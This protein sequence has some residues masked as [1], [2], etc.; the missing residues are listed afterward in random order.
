[1]LRKGEYRIRAQRFLTGEFHVDDLNRLLLYLRENSFGNQ[2]VYDVGNMLGHGDSRTKGISVKRVSD[3]YEIARF[4]FERLGRDVAAPLALDDAPASL[5]AVM[6]ATLRLLSD[7]VLARETGL[8]RDQASTML[9]KIKRK[10]R[11]KADGRIGWGAPSIRATEIALIT[12]L[13]QYILSQPA[14]T[15]DDF[16][17]ETQA[18]LIRHGFMDAGQEALLLRRKPHLILFAIAAMHGA[19]YALPDGETAEAEAGWASD[20]GDAILSVATRMTVMYGGKQVEVMF[21]TFATDLRAEEWAHDYEPER[22]SVTWLS[23]LE[24][25]SEP[26]LRPLV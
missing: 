17:L 3:L 1:M 14:Y 6:D 24:I 7:E 13:T 12:C 15:A 16:F 22:R 2:T 9:T 26:K 18:L 21:P 25:T 19:R 4:Q 5:P 20:T 8:R 23:P 11:A 10:F